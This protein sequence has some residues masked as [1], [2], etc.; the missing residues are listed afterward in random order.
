[1]AIVKYFIFLGGGGIFIKKISIR[2]SDAGLQ[3]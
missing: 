2:I 1:M 3:S